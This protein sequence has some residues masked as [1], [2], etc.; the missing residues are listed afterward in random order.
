M[1]GRNLPSS[2]GF[3]LIKIILIIKLR[4]TT[5]LVLD[6]NKLLKISG[7]FNRLCLKTNNG[8]LVSL[9]ICLKYLSKFYEGFGNESKPNVAGSDESIKNVHCF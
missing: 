1:L 8:V 2:S 4:W 7:K 3:L 6:V 5:N 9:K